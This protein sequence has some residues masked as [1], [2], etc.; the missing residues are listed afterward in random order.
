MLS[1]NCSRIELNAAKLCIILYAQI[2]K[3]LKVDFTRT[4][5]WSDSTVVLSYIRSESGCFQRYVS[6]RVAFI[7]DH[8]N[9]DC[10]RFVPGHLN[11][12]DKLSR[13]IHDMESFANDSTWVNGPHFLKS[14]AESWPA[15][16][17]LNV[18]ESDPEVKTKILTTKLILDSPTQQL[19]NSTQNWFKLSCR[20]AAMLRIR[21][22][23][24]R[25]GVPS[26]RITVDELCNAETAIWKFIQHENFHEVI[27]KLESR[28]DLLI[29]NKLTK[30]SPFI[31]EKGLMRAGGR[32]KHADLCY[33]A[34]H[35]IILPN[36]PLSVRSLVESVHREVGHLGKESIL[37]KLREK[38]YIIGGNS[39]IKTVLRRC[40]TC[41]KMNSRPSQQLMSDL[42]AER[43]TADLPVFTNT[44]VDFF[45][46][47]LVFRGRG[48]VQEKRYGVV[49]SC[50]A[51]RA[52]HLEIACSLETDSFLSALRRFICRRGP[53]KMMRSDQG[54]NLVG[55]QREMAASINEWN[56]CQIDDMCKTNGIQWTFHPAGASN[57]GGI[58]EREVRTIRKTLYSLLNEFANKVRITDELLTTLICEVEDILNNRPLTSIAQD[59]DVEPLTPNHLLKLHSGMNFP[60]GVFSKND[61]YVRR[62]W[63]QAQ[64]IAEVFWQ[65]WRA[66]YLPLLIQRQ[67]WVKPRRSHKIG[68]IVLVVDQKLPR[69]NWCVGRII[70]LKVS[71][72]GLVRSVNV[73]VAK[74]IEDKNFKIGSTILERPVNKI[75]LLQAEDEYAFCA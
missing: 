44:G 10:W 72:D 18:V 52:M 55:G 5:F 50:L 34:K 67:K 66:E 53:V 24:R 33:S 11:V 57:Y 3:E 46:P 41:R 65:R 48:R 36:H 59:N 47:F 26:G 35:P 17:A 61:L 69:N 4:V 60:P 21:K 6:N 68:D 1:E 49:F 16:P 14:G 30:L 29:R 51:S 42:P 20:V 38:F 45:G 56:S 64:F 2:S 22:L 62:K 15:Q 58:F 23:L 8:S 74:Y 71:N 19:L 13:G 54:T 7:R 39:L 43:T 25:K 37:V 9:V 73:R 40:I 63:R 75:V 32:L 31:D 28:Q 12:A 70:S 27:S